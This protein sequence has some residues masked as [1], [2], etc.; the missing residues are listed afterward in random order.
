MLPVLA[1]CVHE[2]PTANLCDSEWLPFD[3][4][5]LNGALRGVD[6][7]KK[8]SILQN[9]EDQ[10]LDH[11]VGNLIF[12]SVERDEN[13]HT[14]KQ[15]DFIQTWK[16]LECDLEFETQ[17]WTTLEQYI[18][19]ASF[20]SITSWN[21]GYS[22]PK[23]SFFG[24]SPLT[25]PPDSFGGSGGQE[26]KEENEDMEHFF[27]RQRGSITRSS[28]KCT[29]YRV[30][31]DIRHEKMQLYPSFVAA[32]RNLAKVVEE[33]ENESK[34]RNKG[35][36]SGKKNY[37]DDGDFSRVETAMIKFIKNYG[38]HYA[39]KITM[40][41][42][43]DFETRFT[44]K[45][46]NEY[47]EQ[48][49]SKCAKNTG[50]VNIFGLKS[51]GGKEDCEKI[52]EEYKDESTNRLQRFV[53]QTYGTLPGRSK[54][55]EDE[56]NPCESAP[57]AD[58]TKVAKEQ[59]LAGTLEPMP[60]KQEFSPIF[61]IF[62][63]DVVADIKKDATCDK[64]KCERINIKVLQK[65]VQD[66]FVNY[67]LYFSR[68]MNY[69]FACART[70]KLKN[71]LYHRDIGKSHDRRFYTDEFGKN[72]LHRFS[73]KSGYFRYWAVSPRCSPSALNF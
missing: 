38:T 70:I 20:S 27:N 71:T 11:S 17:S 31:V 28:A 60:I 16:D 15:L 58:W 59:Y 44:E 47:S 9:I 42:G 41:F 69:E 2:G 18:R 40:G 30:K 53:Q 52:D 61:D 72:Y 35:S 45:E 26:K 57:L 32:I 36:R 12:N 34:A 6:L 67:D 62:E 50:E 24:S 48:I 54:C 21:L 3:F 22:N 64:D 14:F 43:V 73:S 37:I 25:I 13:Q 66:A 39:H 23:T 5:N 51:G 68:D 46:T 29:M 19:R 63:T 1:C 56:K 10:G 33:Y 55:S 8:T 7:P 4:P 65:Y 49:R